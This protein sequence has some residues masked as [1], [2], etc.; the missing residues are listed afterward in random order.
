MAKLKI[1]LHPLFV[2]YVF[3]CIYFGWYNY[4][5]YYVLAVF[6][7]EMG[8]YIVAKHYGYQ[9][10]AMLFAVY[11]AG[12]Q[13]NNAYKAKDDIKISL[14]GPLVNFALIILSVT[15]WWIVPSLYLFTYDFVI[16]NIVVMVFNLLPI[17]PLDGGRILLAVLPKKYNKDKV[18]KVSHIICFI[19]G[20]VFLFVFIISI[21]Y[22]VNYNLLFIGLFL[23][24]NGIMNDRNN[25]F[26]KVKVYNKQLNNPLEVKVFRINELNK[27][28]MIKYL[29]PHYY[30]IFE[31]VNDGKIER[32]EEDSL[33]K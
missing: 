33:I 15:F 25:Y 17:Y 26:D 1:K 6:L 24:L 32:I 10:D 23:S 13:T 20:I 16:C 27:T 3:L 28:K 21:C 22:S 19:L 9:V 8:H 5:F 30:T 31:Y 7:H 29:S 18:L 11:G 14:A 4:I 2:L 12:L